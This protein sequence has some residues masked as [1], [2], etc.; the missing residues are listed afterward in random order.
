M[1]SVFVS[2]RALAVGLRVQTRP[3]TQ[4]DFIR[5]D[6]EGSDSDTRRRAACDL[7]RGLCTL[8]DEQVCACLP[9]GLIVW[10]RF[11]SCL[12]VLAQVTI[13]CLESFQQMMALYAANPA[14]S[15]KSMEAAVALIISLTI[16][17]ETRLFG[18]SHLLYKHL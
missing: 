3:Y 11:F 15:W 16:R 17:G 18:M 9:C 8:F 4:V 6:I 14:A 2:A 12:V 7:I 10:W 1:T 5:Q 13:I